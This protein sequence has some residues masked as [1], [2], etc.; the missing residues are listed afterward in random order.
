MNLPLPRLGVAVAVAA[1]LVAICM[2]WIVPTYFLTTL[3]LFFVWAIVAQGWNLVWGI[4]GV[5]SLGQMAIFAMAGYCT[6]WVVIHTGISTVGAAVI[7]VILSLVASVVMAIP[8]IR[9]KGVYVILFTISFHELFRTLLMTDT[10][11]FTGGQFG[12]PSY[13]GFVSKEIPFS[14]RTRIYY[15]IAFILFLLV[16]GIMVILQKSRLGLAFRAIGQAPLYA[17]SR[18]ISLFKTQTLAFLIGG[19]FAGV[20]GSF[21]SGYFGT[22][23]PGVLSYDTLVLIIAMMVIGGWGTLLGPIL[24]AFL[25]TWLSEALHQAHEFRMIILGSLVVIAAVLFP[26]GLSPQIERFM[27]FVSGKFGK[28][29]QI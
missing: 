2:P 16:T 27:H 18:G 7:G 24:G 15:Y 3:I 13:E 19:L 25:L 29:N 8:S 21:W 20:A 12:L 28:N 11:G 17:A 14:E 9:L 6:G 4:A 5:W 1:I 23:Q 22:M 10:S 26:A